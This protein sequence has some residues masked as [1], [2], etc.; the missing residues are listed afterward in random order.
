MTQPKVIAIDG[1]AGS[2]KS[3]ISFHLADKLGYLFVDTGVFYRAI[4]LMALQQEITLDDHEALGTMTHNARIDIR[5]TP[6]DPARQ[7]TVWIQ[8]Q[9]V[10]SQLRTEQVDRNVSTV[11]A[12]PQVRRELMHVQRYAAEQGNIIMAG[13]DIGTTVLPD[14]DLKLYIDAS[15]EERAR[16]R[17]RQKMESG[18]SVDINEI[19][20][21][22]RKRD[23]EDMNRELSPL[24]QA[25]DA[26]Y[27]LTDNMTIEAVVDR[28]L[29][30][31]QVD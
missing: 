22:L 9:D 27:I 18:E 24:T 4:T 3:T 10:T 30:E 1:P 23:D 14:A 6:D 5:P 21:T 2:G 11:A 7:Y 26:V 13:R 15:I 8:E 31:I 28:I 20:E 17:H 25:E 29:Q 16:R 12:V 19:E